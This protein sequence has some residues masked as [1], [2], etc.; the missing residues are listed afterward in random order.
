M[1]TN[2]SEKRLVMLFTKAL[3]E[4][5]QDWVKSF[6][7]TTLQ[8]AIKKTCDMGN[9]VAKSKT[10]LKPFISPKDK[11]KKPFQCDWPRKDRLDEEM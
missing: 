10:P 2:I 4:P 1:V 8:E 7:P 6:N 11:E 9:V 5:I 3:P